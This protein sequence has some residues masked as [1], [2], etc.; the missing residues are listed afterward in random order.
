MLFVKLGMTT[1]GNP[2]IE[3]RI[4]ICFQFDIKGS[5]SLDFQD[6]FTNVRIS[7]LHE[8]DIMV[9]KSRVFFI[10][11]SVMESNMINNNG[12]APSEHLHIIV[13]GRSR[14][15][16]EEFIQETMQYCMAQDRGQ[17]VIYTQDVSYGTGWTRSISRPQRTLESVILDTSILLFVV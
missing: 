11:R 12:A 8:L 3:R 4:M 14:T 5:I 13:L 6:S 2:T 15:V 9:Y 7:Y 1:T 16:V 17:T 10:W